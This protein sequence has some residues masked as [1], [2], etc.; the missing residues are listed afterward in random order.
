MLVILGAQTVVECTATSAN[1]SAH[2]QLDPDEC[3]RIQA[4]PLNGYATWLHEALEVRN[5]YCYSF[6]MTRY[7]FSKFYCTSVT[8]A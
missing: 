4:K 3:C 1:H 7:I 6:A 5:L 2:E 8:K